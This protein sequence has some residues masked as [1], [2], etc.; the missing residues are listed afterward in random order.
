MGSNAITATNVAPFIPELWST[1]VKAAAE[2]DL[3]FA[4]RVDRKYEKELNYGDTLN[5]PNL[6]NFGDANAVSTTADLTL[7]DTVQNTNAI[8]VNYHYYQAVGLG[9]REQIQNRPDFLKAA[10]TKCGYSVYKMM[11]DILAD[12]V[13]GLTATVGTEGSALTSG[14]LI[15]AYE[16]LNGNDAP[17]GADR[18]WIFD[19]KSVTDLLGI[20]FFVR[21]DYIP[22][23]V[24][25][26]GFQGRQIFGSPVYMTTN[27]NVINTSY[28][29]A[30]YVHKEAFTLLSQM[31]PKIDYFEWPEKF[32][33]VARVQ[34]LF[35]VYKM[36]DTFG[37]WIKT[38]N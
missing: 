13:N 15:N 3:P 35:G 16:S 18:S 2:S 4:Q 21:M 28:H 26:K 25:T 24:V 12:L 34:A 22:D 7:Y 33:T 19:P 31:L 27:L 1:I 32:T 29:A 6:A 14:V 37:V 11:D 20:D 5:V 23:S 9:T 30:A 17:E 8:I 36:R 10:L 38:R